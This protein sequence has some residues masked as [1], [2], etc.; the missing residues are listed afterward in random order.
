MVYFFSLI[1]YSVFTNFNFLIMV[2]HT[3]KYAPHYT[4]SKKSEQPKIE[5]TPEPELITPKG[6]SPKQTN[7]LAIVSLVLSVVSFFGTSGMLSPIS[8]IL[9]LIAKSQIKQTGEEG[10]NLATIAIVLSVI[11]FFIAIVMILCL[12]SIFG[13]SCCF[14]PFAGSGSN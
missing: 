6:S 11:Q 3:E 9:A 10:D 8:L 5:K 7:A 12:G 14:L 1:E 4:Q 13:L 2:T